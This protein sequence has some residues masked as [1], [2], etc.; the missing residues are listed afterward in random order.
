MKDDL[1]RIIK[2]LKSN[3]FNISI[4]AFERMAQRNITA[5]DIITM[6]EKAS[7][8]NP[9]WNNIHQSWNFTGYGLNQRP[10]TIACTYNNEGT[11]IITVF[12]E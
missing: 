2:D 12:W 3:Q 1:E 5:I 11:L 9:K 8:Q 6:I 4:H 10:F 7:L